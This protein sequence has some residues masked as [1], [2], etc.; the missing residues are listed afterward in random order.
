MIICNMVTNEAITTTKTGIL[1]ISGVIF[2]IS[3][4]TRFEQMS[5]NIVASPI[6]RPLIAE[7]VVAKVGHI[8]KRRTNV[9]FSFTIPFNNIFKLFIVLPVFLVF[10]YFGS[11]CRSVSRFIS[12]HTCICFIS[13]VHS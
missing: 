8:P 10:I 13:I 11:S 2:L 3:E 6:D 7:V 5:T 4:I 9:G 1:T 12:N